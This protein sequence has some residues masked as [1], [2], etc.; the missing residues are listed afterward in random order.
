MGSAPYF[1]MC[2]RCMAEL[3]AHNNR[4][5]IAMRLERTGRE[6]PA[7]I[8]RGKMHGSGRGSE[9]RDTVRREV[10]CSRGHTFWTHHVDAAL[11]PNTPPDAVASRSRTA[12]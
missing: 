7:I 11:L 10:T 4:K 2:R 9:R 6:R 1:L 12:P 8:P 3:W 5:T